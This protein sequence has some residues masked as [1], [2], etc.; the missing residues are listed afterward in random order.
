MLVCESESEIVSGSVLSLRWWQAH[1]AF[2]QSLE[3]TSK[4]AGAP[5]KQQ[6]AFPPGLGPAP[7]MPLIAE[8]QPIPVEEEEE[9]TVT[10][11]EDEEVD[12]AMS[13]ARTVMAVGAM[14]AQSAL[15][16]KITIHPSRFRRL[17]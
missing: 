14:R 12:G 1:I 4:A 11:D 5:P 16:M 13:L 9:G 15:K 8:Q 2:L 10:C 3:T 6:A 17:G 7:P